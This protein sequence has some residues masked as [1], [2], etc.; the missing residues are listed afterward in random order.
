LVV[1]R[2]SEFESDAGGTNEAKFRSFELCRRHITRPEILTFDE[3]FERAKF[4]VSEG[5]D[6]A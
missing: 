3:L 6:L 2:L 4:I 1:G 5:N